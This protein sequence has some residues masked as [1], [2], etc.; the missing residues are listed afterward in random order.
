MRVI[1]VLWISNII[2]PEVCRHFQLDIPSVGGWMESG[3]KALV[4]Y[5]KGNI[6]LSVAATYPGKEIRKIQILDIT[7]YLVPSDS[8]L[9]ESGLIQIRNENNFKLVHIHGTE[10]QHSLTSIRVFN[11]VK[12][13]VSIQGLVS[14][15]SKFYFG[16]IE[17][18][19]RRPTIR[20]ILRVDS[21]ATQQRKME[22]R[23][24]YEIETIKES[25]NIIGRTDWDLSQVWAINPA[26][27]YH[28]CNET[29]RDSFYYHSWSYNNC[30]KYS[31]F[32]SQAHYPIKGLHQVLHAMPIVKYH[33]PNVKIYIAGNNFFETSFLKKTAYARYINKLIKKYELISNIKFLGILEEKEMAIRYKSSH[34]FVCP[35]SIENSANSIGEAQLIGVPVVA[36]YVGGSMDMISHGVNGFLYRYE[37]YSMLGYWIC[38][39]FE[40]QILSDRLSR[41]AKIVAAKRHSAKNNGE[42]LANIYNS[43]LT[44]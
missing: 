27:K 18:K 19:D 17:E 43:I 24:L 13:V 15:Y 6:S 10:Y 5:A 28:F 37:E 8:S 7:Y 44:E 41:S 35:S 1:K 30:E 16:G 38:Q 22:Q 33:Y 20:D 39:L 36:S 42:N 9:L 29:L 21:L 26:C 31:I 34:V 11:S 3:A 12:S 2:F 32:I 14:V 23:G 4:K 40:S 25:K